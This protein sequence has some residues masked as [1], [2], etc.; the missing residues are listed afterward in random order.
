MDAAAELTFAKDCVNKAVL[1]DEAEV[2]KVVRYNARRKVD[3]V[4]TGHLGV[5]AGNPF[6]DP[7]FHFIGGW[8]HKRG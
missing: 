7:C 2:G 4:V 8:H 5:R 3:V 6:F 1:F